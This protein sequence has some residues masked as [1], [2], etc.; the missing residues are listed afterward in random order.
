MALVKD[1]LDALF[2][3]FRNIFRKPVTVMY[4]REKRPFPERMRGVFA[5]TL[6][7]KTGEENCIGCRLCEMICPSSVIKVV[8]E[9]RE[10]RSY[11]REFT[12]DMGGCMFCELCVQ[13]C[14]TDAIVMTKN[15]EFSAYKREDLVLTKEKLLE[16]GKKY[17]LSA[18]TGNSLRKMQTPPRAEVRREG[19][20]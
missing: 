1:T 16:I 4:P 20:K 7:P 18:N 6:N 8:P 10:N 2:I 19:G 9:K 13:V 12:L 11:S 3:T 14:P 5:Q 15:V 17:S